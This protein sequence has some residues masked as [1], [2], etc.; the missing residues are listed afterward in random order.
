M[1]NPELPEGPARTSLEVFSQDGSQIQSL[2]PEFGD[3][4]CLKEPSF[5]RA[6]KRVEVWQPAKL[7]SLQHGT[8]AEQ[9]VSS[10][11]PTG[12]RHKVQPSHAT[13]GSDRASRQH[14]SFPSASFRSDSRSDPERLTAPKRAAL[15][16]KFKVKSIK[17]ARNKGSFGERIQTVPV[18]ESRMFFKPLKKMTRFIRI[19]THAPRRHVQQVERIVCAVG[20]GPVRH[21]DASRPKRS[22]PCQEASARDGLRPSTR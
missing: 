18:D 7:H 10:A 1:T 19:R 8:A 5:F 22:A 21:G 3:S 12:E 16:Q 11:D 9:C 14:R 17:P 15:N 4:R 20:H 13:A 2:M 6:S